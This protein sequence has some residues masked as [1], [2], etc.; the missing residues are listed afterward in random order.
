[1][2]DTRATAAV[3]AEVRERLVEIGNEPIDQLRAAAEAVGIVLSRPLLVSVAAVAS[4]MIAAYDA[5]RG[6][7]PRATG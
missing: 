4:G 5:E 3:F 2:R 7:W 6:R 1:M